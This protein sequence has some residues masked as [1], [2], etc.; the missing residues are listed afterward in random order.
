MLCSVKRGLLERT[1]YYRM[2]LPS[3]FT[4]IDA[5]NLHCSVDYWGETAERTVEQRLTQHSV[6]MTKIT[7]THT[8]LSPHD[9]KHHGS[10]SSQYT[11]HETPRL[12]QHSVHMT[13]NT[14]AHTALSP[15]DMKHHGSHSSQ[16][17]RHETPRLTQHSVHMTSNTTAHTALSPHN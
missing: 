11:R 1:S 13:R 12:T 5:G 9:M 8:A 16:Y 3:P 14:T 17:T 6:H 4:R 10:H 2:L 15:H 7:T